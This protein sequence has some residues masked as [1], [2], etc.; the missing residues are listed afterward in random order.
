MRLLR[1]AR[2]LRRQED[3]K[4]MLNGDTG[5]GTGGNNAFNVG[6][7][8]MLDGAMGTMLQKAG[9]NLGKVPEDINIKSPETVVD[10]HR[11]YIE[12]GSDIIMQIHSASTDIGGRLRVHR[13]GTYRRRCEEREK[14][15]GRDGRK[16]RAVGGT[17]RNAAGA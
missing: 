10:I 2:E 8:V 6:K 13:R 5:G 12:S 4:I 14:S 7:L 1:Q 17:G 9:V 3:R 16:N 15:G 11:Q